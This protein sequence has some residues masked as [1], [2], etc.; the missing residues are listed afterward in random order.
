MSQ[1]PPSSNPS[2]EG[3]P[4]ELQPN[5]AM[6]APVARRAASVQLRQNDADETD[7]RLAMDPAN[8]ALAGALL[9]TY[10]LLQLTM[11]GLLAWFVVS[12]LQ[13]VKETERGLRVTFGA[14]QSDELKAGFAFSLPKLLGEI[15]RVE[16]TE[17]AIEMENDFWP[18]VDPRLRDRPP[19]ELENTAKASVDPIQDGSM[20]TADTSIAHAK[21]QVRF[22]RENV[23]QWTESMLPEA[24]RK[25]VRA[26]VARAVT[27]AAATLTID[28]IIK[29]QP[30]KAVRAGGEGFVGLEARALPMAQAALDEM[31][32][33]IRITSLRM[34]TPVPPLKLQSDFARVD[35]AQTEGRTEVDRA[36]QE[37]DTRLLATAGASA[38][39]LLSLIDDL[40]RASATPGQEAQRER[41]QRDIE[42]LLVSEPGQTI[43]LGSREGEALAAQVS[44]RAANL[45]SAARQYRSS[46]VSRAQADA[47]RYQA[48]LA[49]FRANPG[50]M[51]LGDWTSAFAEFA[52]KDNVTFMSV[53]EG[54]KYLQLDINRDPRVAREQEAAQIRREVEKRQ[55]DIMRRSDEQFID[56]MGRPAPK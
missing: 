26:A 51:L 10:R 55:S 8:Q 54:T 32:S 38:R 36:Q 24:E 1:L 19:Q 14:L 37:Y 45:L 2:G 33:G 3:L 43:K 7:P 27:H 12:G 50:V 16:T 48:K 23:R 6:M 35:L 34:I 22:R 21:F 4:P 42:A 25:M 39:D 20:V 44:G 53:P 49:A 31:G 11:V 47:S 41:I 15:V 29:N 17:N 56:N 28:E 30:D 13:S 5:P 46:V 52:A 40:D 18:V 9:V